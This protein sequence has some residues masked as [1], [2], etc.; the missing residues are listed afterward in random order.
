M[1]RTKNRGIRGPHTDSG[2][3]SRRKVQFFTH[4]AFVF[5]KTKISNVF[6]IF[7]DRAEWAQRDLMSKENILEKADFIL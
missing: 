3:K 5:K 6:E 2:Q 7:I 1:N 4:F